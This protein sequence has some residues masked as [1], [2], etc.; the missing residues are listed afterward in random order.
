MGYSGAGGKLIHEKNQK[1]K[2]RDSVPLK[3]A[4][5]VRNSKKICD[6]IDILRFL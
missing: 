3:K 2:S 4:E 6:L 1:Q 5:K